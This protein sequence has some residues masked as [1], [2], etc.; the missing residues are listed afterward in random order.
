[1]E[2]DNT[3]KKA[4]LT[5][6]IEAKGNEIWTLDSIASANKKAGAEDEAKRLI[7][8]SATASR[9]KECLEEQLKELA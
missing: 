6:H 8:L 5:A 7:A 2:L 1:M 9:V 3:Q 4:I